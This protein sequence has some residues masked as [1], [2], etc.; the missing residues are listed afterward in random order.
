[1]GIPGF[2]GS[3]GDGK[4]LIDESD[5][6]HGLVVCGNGTRLGTRRRRDQILDMTN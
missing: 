3:F 5:Q 1:V 4:P 6:D 2:P